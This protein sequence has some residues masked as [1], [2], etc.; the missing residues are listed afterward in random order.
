MLSACTDTSAL[1]LE[2][3]P[4][5]HQARCSAS[6]ANE[7]QVRIALGAEVIRSQVFP[8]PDLCIYSLV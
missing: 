3:H 6:R 1:A 7:A 4:S 5:C 2:E 8:K